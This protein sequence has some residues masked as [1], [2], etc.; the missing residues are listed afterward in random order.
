MWYKLGMTL[1][2][3]ERAALEAVAESNGLLPLPELR[4]EVLRRLGLDGSRTRG[5]NR[6]LAQALQSLDRQGFVEVYTGARS[7]P[8]NRHASVVGRAVKH[9]KAACCTVSEEERQ[10]M[11]HV[12]HYRVAMFEATPN[13][14]NAL[15]G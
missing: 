1:T 12:K 2:P 9:H 5:F 15:R 6:L 10:S 3:T 11:K 4:K 13:G 8:R 7:A 14:R